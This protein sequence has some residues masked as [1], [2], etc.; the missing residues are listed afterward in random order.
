MNGAW[1]ARNLCSISTASFVLM[2]LRW[3][4]A[5]NVAKSWHTDLKNESTLQTIQVTMIR[6][7]H[8]WTKW[9]CGAVPFVQLLVGVRSD[10]DARIHL[11]DKLAKQLLVEE[12]GKERRPARKHGKRDTLQLAGSMQHGL[13]ASWQWANTYE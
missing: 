8:V 9:V 5:A 4:F 3:S 11:P 13:R 2:V 1:E 12:L 6:P 7:T 10:F